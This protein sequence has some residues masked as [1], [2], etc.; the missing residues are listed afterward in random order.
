MLEVVLQIQLNITHQNLESGFPSSQAVE[1]V[2]NRN[3]WSC[4]GSARVT[5]CSQS[6]HLGVDQMATK[7][8]CRLSLDIVSNYSLYLDWFSYPTQV[9][10]LYS[11][12]K[13]SVLTQ[14]MILEV[15][16]L[17]WSLFP[18]VFIGI[19]IPKTIFLDW[20]EQLELLMVLLG[21]L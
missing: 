5:L 18:A 3:T 19:I 13:H 12:R 20:E 7:V 9:H 21:K 8:L 17:L 4:Q 10:S 1:Q 6:R 11:P 2:K 16:F 15:I 14:L